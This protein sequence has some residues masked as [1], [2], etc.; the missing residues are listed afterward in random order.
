MKARSSFVLAAAA[1]LVMTLSV[2]L[3]ASATASADATTAGSSAVIAA[4]E[5][6]AYVNGVEYPGL[7][8]V[9]LFASAPGC[10]AGDA[11][12]KRVNTYQRRNPSGVAK[13]ECGSTN[14]YG[15]RHIAS[16]KAQDWQNILDKWKIESTWADFAKWNISNTVGAPASAPYNSTNDTYTYQAPLQI[17]DANGKV[18]RTYTVK[19]PVGAKTERI[20]T[21][22]PS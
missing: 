3:S 11:A 2:P 12:T 19:V 21:A 10:A 8:Q 7:P 22:F 15:W 1:A 14:G 9:S 20:I 4:E 6:T 5:Y 13:L 16:G 17:K 18:V